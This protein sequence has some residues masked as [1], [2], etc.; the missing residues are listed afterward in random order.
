MANSGKLIASIVAACSPFKPA[1]SLL[2]LLRKDSK[3]LFEITEEF[4]EKVPKLQI[5]SFF[6][7]KKTSFTIFKRLVCH[8]FCIL[9]GNGCLTVYL[10]CG[11][12]FSNPQCPERGT[13]RAICGSSRYCPV[14]FCRRPQLQT[15]Y[16][17][18]SQIW[19]GYYQ[20]VSV[21]S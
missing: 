21:I 10:G 12:T 13:N 2:G 18:P 14:L 7:M 8:I 17:T 11:A 5:V 15:G 20:E 19:A 16:W 1:R 6:E 3:V 4:V 9:T